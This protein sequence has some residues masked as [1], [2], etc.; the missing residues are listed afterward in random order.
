M[1]HIENHEISKRDSSQ[2]IRQLRVRTNLRGGESVDACMRNLDYW[3]KQYY[4]WYDK[5]QAKHT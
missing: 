2:A 1:D 5:A 3:Q 4:Y